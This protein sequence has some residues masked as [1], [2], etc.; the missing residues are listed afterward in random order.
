M[1]KK[2]VFK[3][4]QVRR[5]DTYLQSKVTNAREQIRAGSYATAEDVETRF[6]KRRA[7]LK[8]KAAGV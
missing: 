5:N 4:S 1:S 3:M 8:T 2:A 6:A 7:Q